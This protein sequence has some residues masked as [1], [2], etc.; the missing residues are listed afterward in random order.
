MRVALV[1][2]YLSQD[3]GAER[4]LRSFHDIWP[5][6]P[7]FTLFHD[8]KR[9]NPVFN[10]WDVRT[11]F[12]QKFPAARR[13]Y[14]WFLPLMPTATESHDLDDYDLVISSSSVFAKGVLTRPGTIHVCYCHTPTRFLWSDAHDY[15]D[16]LAI[17]GALKFL[18]SPVLTSQRVWDRLAAERVDFFIAN[19][20]TVRERIRRYYGADSVVVSPPVLVHQFKPA[21][22]PGD[23]FLA[24]GRLVSYKRFDLVVQAFN[25]LGIPLK[26]FGTGPEEKRLRALAGRKVELL[27][28]VSEERKIDLYSRAR[29][30]IHPHIEDFGITAIEAMASG[31][32]VIAFGAGG[33][34]ETIL[35]GVSGEFLEEQSWENLAH[36]VIRFDDLRY[37]ALRIREHAEKFA[38]PI[39]REKIRRLVNDFV[40]VRK[41]NYASRA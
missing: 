11:S 20:E 30:F 41:N 39:F 2:D 38:A 9:A 5:E 37:N 21:S 3:G 16:D 19:S 23:Y 31:R 8:T 18:L 6:A 32:P 24:G 28:Q 33:A 29:A 12:L 27:G 14:R 15:V 17:P 25:K 10:S 40:T 22:E 36:H 1:H 34:L 7:L 4:V 13:H 35:P 26:I